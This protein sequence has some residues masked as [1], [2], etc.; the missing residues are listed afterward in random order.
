MQGVKPNG[1]LIRS[2]LGMIYEHRLNFCAFYSFSGLSMH[3]LYDK[4]LCSIPNERSRE[5][6]VFL[7]RGVQEMHHQAFRT[8]LQSH[9]SRAFPIFHL[10]NCTLGN[11]ARFKSHTLSF[12]KY[13][14]RHILSLIFQHKIV[15]FYYYIYLQAFSA[16]RQYLHGGADKYK[17]RLIYYGFSI[18]KSVGAF[19]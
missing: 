14:A 11:Y 16:I 1:H 12:K 3:L 17:F 13:S 9:G 8:S 6:P 4:A 7:E 10:F 18:L 2:G 15:S 19:Q 5:R